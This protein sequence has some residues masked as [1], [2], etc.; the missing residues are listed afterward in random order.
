MRRKE[1]KDYGTKKAIEGVFQP[2][3]TCL[4]IE[5]LITSGSS[6]LETLEPLVKEGLIVKDVVVLLDREQGGKDNLRKH[7]IQLHSVLK[8]TDILEILK[9]SGRLS[10]DKVAELFEYFHSTQVSS[11]S[12]IPSGMASHNLSFEQRLS[13]IRNKV[14]RRLLEIVLKKQSNL[15]VAADVTTSQELLSIASQVGPHICV[16]KTHVDIIEDWNERVCEQLV[17]LAKSHQFLIFEDRKFADI[18]NTVELQFTGG[19]FHISQWAD[20]V[21][22]HIIAG[23]GT[24]QA[25]RKASEHCGI[26]LLAQMSSKGNLAVEEYTQKAIQ[27]AKQYEDAVFGFISMGCIGEPNFIYF[28]PGV[29]LEKGGDS[30]GQQY[31]DPKT[32][33][34]IQKSDI[35]IVGRGIIHASDRKEAALTYQKACWDAYVQRIGK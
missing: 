27:F 15:S 22:A 21:N 29:K 4:I 31:T 20:M 35:A 13:M 17:H 26:L 11:N 3:Q 1:V 7:N 18:G 32:V 25:L 16:L 19:I 14:G 30:L 2:N 23:P 5:D 28:T 8:M 24:I 34:G 9:D 33:I 10:A 6:V 12:S